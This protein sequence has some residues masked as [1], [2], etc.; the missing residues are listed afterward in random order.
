MDPKK[1]EVLQGTLDLM[2]L[3]TL[4]GLRPFTD[5]ASSAASSSSARKCCN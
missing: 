3:K 4:H 1:T 5:S 2:I